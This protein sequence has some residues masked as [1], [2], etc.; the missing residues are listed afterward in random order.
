ML[1]LYVTT[2]SKYDVGMLLYY[3]YILKSVSFGI[4]AVNA[5]KPLVGLTDAFLVKFIE[6]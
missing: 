1:F 5:D 2:E 6:L 3:L 4:G